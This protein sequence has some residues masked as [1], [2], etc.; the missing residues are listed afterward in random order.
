MG[1]TIEQGNQTNEVK[2]GKRGKKKLKK[3]VFDSLTQKQQI[4]AL[5]DALV[6][7]LRAIEGGANGS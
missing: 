4:D 1:I 2:Q 7:L 3:A 6:D 5:R